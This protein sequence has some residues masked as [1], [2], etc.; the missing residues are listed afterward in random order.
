MWTNIGLIISDKC[1]EISVSRVRICNAWMMLLVWLNDCM[2]KWCCS[3][4]LCVFEDVLVNMVLV[5]VVQYRCLYSFTDNTVIISD[6]TTQIKM[7]LL[8]YLVPLQSDTFHV[9]APLI[10]ASPHFHFKPQKRVK[11]HTVAGNYLPR[12]VFLSKP[13]QCL[14]I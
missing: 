1:S 5:S 7:G 4:L 13:R 9:A 12:Q 6:L 14:D 11:L 8:L 10:K 3:F 2:Y